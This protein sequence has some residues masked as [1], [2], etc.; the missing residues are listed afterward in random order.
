MKNLHFIHTILKKKPCDGS[1]GDTHT[2]VI[3][4]FL[5]HMLLT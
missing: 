2:K 5:L 1:A 4:G 3:G